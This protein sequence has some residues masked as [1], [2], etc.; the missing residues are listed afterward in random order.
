MKKILFLHGFFASGSCEM[1]QALRAALA[2]KA[3]VVTP[4][5]PLHPHEALR[6]IR[7]AIEHERPDLIVGNSC[8][9]FYAQMVAPVA[10]VPALLG[11]PHFCMSQFLSER[12]G[13]HQYK[14]LRAD[15]N[16][17]FTVDDGLVAEFAQLE[18]EQFDCCNPYY[19]D[20]VWGLF[21]EADELAHYEP[22]FRSHYSRSFHFPG[23]HTP[24][25]DEV[26]RWYAPLAVRMLDELPAAEER[27]FRHFKGGLYRYLLSALDS[28]TK[29]RKVV[30]QALY[31]ER[32]YWVRPERMFFE[33]VVRDGR[34]LQRFSEIGPRCAEV[35]VAVGGEKLS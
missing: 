31:G 6:Q 7:I 14:A 5:L 8:G 12:I 18:K 21:G 16:Q 33:T 1:A 15:G 3:E 26:W 32:S 20:R 27:Y 13:S 29:E 30:Y 22:L 11:N 25:A 2:T 34:R 28:E 17:T 23:R 24:T 19:S 4:D 10:G 35:K 9:A